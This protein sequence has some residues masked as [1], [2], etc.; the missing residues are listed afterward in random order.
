MLFT[1]FLYTYWS[2][3]IT[4]IVIQQA[5]GWHFQAELSGLSYYGEVE[6][7]QRMLVPDF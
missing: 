7:E 1:A 6:T 2:I 5:G 4:S 3:Y